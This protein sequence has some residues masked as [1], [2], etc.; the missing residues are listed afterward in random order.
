MKLHLMNVGRKLRCA[1]DF[2]LTVSPVAPDESE[3]TD[4]TD[5]LD[6][7]H[8]LLATFGEGL[9][10]ARPLVVSFEGSPAGVRGKMWAG[11][12]WQGT[13]EVP[14]LLA[15]SANNYFSL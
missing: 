15:P 7:V 14:T 10:T 5:S 2:K 12:P 9:T 6:N 11:S 13:L 8:F 4:K 1:A 3:K